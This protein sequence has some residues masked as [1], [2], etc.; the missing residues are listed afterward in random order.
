MYG[1]VL[2]DVI[3]LYALEI[4]FKTERYTT[5]VIIK[6]HHGGH[7]DSSHKCTSHFGGV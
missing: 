2:F 5:V 1:D 6:V 7:A 4:I 3:I